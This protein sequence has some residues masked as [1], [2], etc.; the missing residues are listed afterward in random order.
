VTGM[1]ERYSAE[2]VDY[3]A[4]TD[5]VRADV[6][7]ISLDNLR[8]LLAN[9]ADDE[10]VLQPE[11][12][13]RSRAGAA[14]R[15]RQGVSLESL[16][17]AFRLWGLMAWEEILAEADL[18]NPLEREAALRAAGRVIEHMERVSTAVA[19]AYLDEA[20]GLWSDREVLR[21]DLLEAL[22]AGRGDSDETR[23][24]AEALGVRLADS[25]VAV[26]ARA[27]RVDLEALAARA[28]MRRAVDVAHA[29]LRPE[30]GEP[31][32]GMREGEVV[33]L[34]PAG[35]PRALERVRLGAEEMAGRLAGEGF[36]IG[37]GSWHPGRGGV[38]A[39]YAEAREA[40]EI[41]AADGKAHAVAFDEV[42]IDSMLRSST[43]AGRVLSDTLEPLR[44]YDAHRRAELV[45]TLRAYIGSGF[46]LT[47]S[48]GEL[49]VHPNTVVYR[50]KRIRELTGRD[51]H[52]PDDLLLLTLGLR[53]LDLGPR[54]R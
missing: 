36:G 18:E 10:V 11:Q 8:A 29:R 54:G 22:V 3:A 15:V 14:R 51:P 37:V 25:Y 30:G 28:A 27:H 48:A 40:A 12:L 13:A 26:V 47:R 43:H 2:I 5:D 45:P 33:A 9:L 42:A 46:N 35:G 38:A 21:R 16:L 6:Y 24:Q 32:V 52:D 4:L 17:H 1:V 44:D 23:R 50:L 31:L 20:Q 19:Q 53:L 39:G 34:C 7:G 41:A 49:C